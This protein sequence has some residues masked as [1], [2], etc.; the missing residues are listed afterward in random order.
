MGGTVGRYAK[1]VCEFGEFLSSGIE[2]DAFTKFMGR[3]DGQTDGC[4]DPWTV[5]AKL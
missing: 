4:T 1:S 2:G 3:K 5:A